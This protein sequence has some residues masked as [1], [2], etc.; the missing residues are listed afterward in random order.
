MIK[1]LL[2]MISEH[3]AGG[4]AVTAWM[5]M[6]PRSVGPVVG[7]AGKGSGVSTSVRPF[8]FSLTKNLGPKFLTPNQQSKVAFPILCL[9]PR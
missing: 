5:R 6:F 4:L 8:P 1:Q 3:L 2:L 9:P 7:A